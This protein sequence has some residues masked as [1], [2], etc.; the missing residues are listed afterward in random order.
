MRT[1]VRLALLSTVSL[2]VYAAPISLD[3]WFRGP[4]IQ[5]VSIS[6][7]GRYLAII[8]RD[9]D[10]AWVAVKDRSA[11]GAAKTIFATDPQQDI[12]PR[13]CEWVGAKRLVWVPPGDG[14]SSLRSE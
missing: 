9:G 13:R 14:D 1:L 10:D 11:G 4:Q 12:Q 7:D 8:A 6:F 3:D 2:G 5:D